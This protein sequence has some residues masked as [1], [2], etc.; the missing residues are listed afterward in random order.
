[1]STVMKEL[2][3]EISRL[4]RKEVHREL[5]PV[6]RIGATQRTWIAGL[7][8]QIAALQAEVKSLRKAA[9]SGA[10]ALAIPTG[11]KNAAER[12]FWI[13]GQG[14]RSLRKRLGVTQVE[15]GI[16]AGV[17]SQT[18]VNWEGTKGKIAL[19]QKET[20]AKL[21][22]IRALTRRSARKILANSPQAK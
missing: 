6:K 14:V 20:G 4:A 2:K 13:S 22:G 8:R 11:A 21:Q 5:V 1:M 7:R 19:R 17:T 16:L 18:V 3:A 12:R 15:L 10:A 9:A